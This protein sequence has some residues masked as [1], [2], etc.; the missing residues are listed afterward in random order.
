[1]RLLKRL[2]QIISNIVPISQV[3]ENEAEL[4]AKLNPDKFYVENVRSILDVS[5]A[6][7]ARICETAVRQGIFERRV[8]VKCPDGAVAASAD[9]EANLP[10]HVRC[11]IQDEGHLE[12][13]E[14][15]TKDL[16][17]STFY[18]LNDNSDSLSFGQTA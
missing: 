11:W 9:I 12:A 7:A 15:P 10:E 1:M 18:R 14:L 6:S 3:S 4:L 17:K 8:E 5:Y 2:F 13:V 16:E